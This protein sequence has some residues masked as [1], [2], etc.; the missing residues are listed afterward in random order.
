MLKDNVE[1]PIMMFEKLLKKN[2]CENF[3]VASSCAVY[4]KKSEILSE[5]MTLEPCN[6]YGKSK[7][8]FEEFC[9]DFQ[10]KAKV[11]CLRYSNVYGPEEDHKGK[12]ASM[13]SQ[14]LNSVFN[15]KSP[16]LFKYGEQKRDWVYVSDVVDANILSINMPSGIYNCGN[17]TSRSFN[18]IIGVI[19]SFIPDYKKIIPEYIDNPFLDK[20]QEFTQTDITK[21]SKFGYCPK[22]DLEKGIEE[23][24][25][26]AS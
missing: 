7:K 13:V 12:R 15:K 2:D 14:I 21:L 17:G 19:N 20:Y 1:Q 18:E 26:K 24:M 11:V 4:G 10:N 9:L 23:L 6:V 5:N 25:K 22:F 16:K 3:V 8:I